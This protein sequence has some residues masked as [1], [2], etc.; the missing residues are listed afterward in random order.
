MT[1]VVEEKGLFAYLFIYLL[2]F[3]VEFYVNLGFGICAEKKRWKWWWSW[4]PQNNVSCNP[5][6][7]AD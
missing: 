2:L 4:P 5:E 6:I 7:S 1:K 3:I